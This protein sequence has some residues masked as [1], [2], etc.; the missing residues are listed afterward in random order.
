MK[1]EAENLVPKNGSLASC[2]RPLRPAHTHVPHGVTLMQHADSLLHSVASRLLHS[3]TSFSQAALSGP[4]ILLKRLGSG[5]YILR[6]QKR[7]GESDQP[8]VIRHALRDTVTREELVPQSTTCEQTQ[9]FPTPQNGPVEAPSPSSPHQTQAESPQRIPNHT[10]WFRPSTQ[11]FTCTETPSAEYV[12]S[13]T[14]FLPST[15]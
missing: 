11:I 9:P 8:P 10:A 14:H 4:S 7:C 13:I 5:S 3:L 15:L 1:L 6:K 2:L 12:P